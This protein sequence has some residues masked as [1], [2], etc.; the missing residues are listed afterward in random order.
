[1][2]CSGGC[3]GG[4]SGGCGGNATARLAGTVDRLR[5]RL[6]AAGQRAYGV[7]LVWTAWGG[8]E[9]GEGRER[10]LARVTITPPPEVQDLTSIALSPYGAGVLP[11]GSLRISRVTLS[12]SSD[13]LEGRTVPGQPYPGA[14][15]APAYPPA[16]P[17]GALTQTDAEAVAALAP[18]SVD[19]GNPP[20]NVAFFYE[21][22]ELGRPSPQ[23]SKY[24]LL[25]TPFRDAKRFG[26]TFVLE[27]ISAD[28]GRDGQPSHAEELP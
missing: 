21:V 10:E 17:L 14:C 25:S 27:R 22:Y 23:R 6:A 7:D 5:G 2:G 28:R 18:P 13:D 24:R 20:R 8:D 15:G 19:D 12:L 26:W 11:I 3:G 1:M 4:C 9:R 16:R